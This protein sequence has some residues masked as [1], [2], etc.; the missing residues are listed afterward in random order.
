MKRMA[1]QG[2]NLAQRTEDLLK[3][4]AAKPSDDICEIFD[5]TIGMVEKCVVVYEEE[6]SKDARELIQQDEEVDFMTRRF[7]GSQHPGHA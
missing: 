4:G 2:V 5:L 1:D 6:D 7:F 3:V